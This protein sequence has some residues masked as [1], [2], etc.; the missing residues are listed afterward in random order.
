M[1]QVNPRNSSGRRAFGL[2]TRTPPRQVMLKDVK[3][4]RDH[5]FWGVT[6]FLKPVLQ[7]EADAP[8]WLTAPAMKRVRSNAAEVTP[9]S[10]SS[11][12]ALGAALLGERDS[13]PKLGASIRKAGGKVGAGHA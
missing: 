7:A 11:V 12:L 4:P 6:R 3:S 13:Q 1:I 5:G 2:D 10:E 8:Q 9:R